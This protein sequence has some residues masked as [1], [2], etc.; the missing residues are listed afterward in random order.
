MH[1]INTWKE[2]IELQNEFIAAI[3]RIL[4]V[5]EVYRQEVCLYVQPPQ[6]SF[7]RTDHANVVN[8]HQNI[9]K[10]DT[11]PLDHGIQ[12]SQKY[13]QCDPLLYHSSCFLEYH[14]ETEIQI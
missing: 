1:Y 4:H 6:N 11:I 2:E 3:D 9:I 5:V 12:T 10:E 13:K 8:I 14:T 7:T